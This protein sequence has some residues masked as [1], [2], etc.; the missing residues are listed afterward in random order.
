MNFH[1]TFFN[2]DFKTFAFLL[3]F[4]VG[5]YSQ[6]DS[7]WQSSDT[8]QYAEDQEYAEEEYVPYVPP[9]LESQPVRPVK[10]EQWAEATKDLDYSKDRPRPPKEKKPTDVSDNPGF[11][12]I[13]WTSATQGLGNF[14]QALAV[15]LA[16]IGIAYGIYRMLKA[17]RNRVIARD[18]VEITLDN[19][20]EYL[21]E[22]D[23]DRFLREALEKSDYPLAVRIYYLQIIKSLSEKN[24]I[25]WSREKTNRDYL[26][27]TR[28]YRL[29]ESFRVATRAYE[30][31][32]YGNQSLS[33]T[34]YARLEPE[35]KNLL[36]AI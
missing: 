5:G 33:A 24:A 30:R 26:R 3:L 29:G 18:G 28:E 19:L 7:L 14:F 9:R 34:D 6:S 31:V 23:L 25:K 32:W 4:P 20:D 2:V 27:E 12:A 36:S 17:P 1:S 21:H 13:D 16:I 22:T 8:L 10:K 11:N 35:F 15:I